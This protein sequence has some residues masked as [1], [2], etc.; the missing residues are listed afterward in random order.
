MNVPLASAVEYLYEESGILLKIAVFV[1]FIYALLPKPTYKTNVK[2]PTI[3][4]V[5]PWLPEIFSRLLFN[6]YA[7]SVIYGGYA[8]YKASGYKIL[9][10]DGDLVV[11]PTKYVEELRQLPASTLN[12]LEATFSDHVG[13]YTT[14]L[15][16]SHLHTETIQKRL[17]PAIGR[18]IPRITSELEYAFQVELPSCEDRFVAIN[19]YEVF[20]RLVARVGARIFIGDEL[21]REEKWIEASIEYTKNIFLTIALMRPVPGFLHPI[22]GRMLP[23]SRRL[24]KQLSYIQSELLGPLI[25]KRRNMEAA[26]DPYYKKPDDFLQWMMDLAKTETESQPSNLAH[27]LLGLTSMA[28]VHTSAMSMTHIL[29]DLLVMPQWK[30]PLLD[31]ILTQLPEWGS[32]SQANLNNLKIM[33]SFLKESQRFNPPGELSF[34]RVVKQD[35]TLS[36]GLFLP[37]GTHICMASGPISR[38]PDVIENPAAFDAF[39]YTKQNAQTSGFV[40]TGSQHMHFG[41]GRYACPGRFFASFVMKLVLSRFLMD[42]EFKFAPDQTKRPNNL[43]IGDKIVPNVSTA[44]FIKRRASSI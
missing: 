23:S 44:I 31:E 12:A 1:L 38:D 25:A 33:D 42:Y 5:S 3:K 10:P 9:K 21:C 29:Y 22:V 32:I 13:E 7:P 41:L 34:H 15:T 19:S 40:S 11:L 18:L 26:S 6:S 28:V 4:F 30:K 27:R 8:K 39:R 36:D 16:D 17:T 24:D 35:L 20:L 43:L 2:V 37:K 14:I